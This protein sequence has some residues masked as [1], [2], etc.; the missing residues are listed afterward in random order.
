MDGS[1]LTQQGSITFIGSEPVE[2][3]QPIPV[4]VIYANEGNVHYEVQSSVTIYDAQGDVLDIVESE[5]AM[6]LPGY[7]RELVASWVPDSDLGPGTYGAQAIVYL[8]DGTLLDEANGSF[9]LGVP[10]VRP[11]PSTSVT[12]TADGHSI[13]ETEDGTISISIPQGA[14]F[15]QVEIS[16]QS[17]PI[18]QLA[19][20]PSGY[21][22]AAAAFRVEGL[23][24]LLA[25]E[26]TV[27][28]QYTATDLHRA[29][30]EAARLRL[31]RWD[32]AN[33][34]WIV[35]ETKL[36]PETMTISTTTDRF[37]IWAIMV[38]PPTKVNWI[39]IGGMAA[40]VIVV[41]LLVY[42]LAVRRRP[43]N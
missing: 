32:E 13:L 29:E 37:S 36:D 39:P 4:K 26:A 22:L 30:G 12:I 18:E 40:G 33:S 11:S 21:H 41:A 6:V 25:K 15:S 35:L 27:A 16:L 17:Y 24:G 10:Y 42:F 2:S 14:V 7:S 28:V 23:P 31:A 5:M 3:G 8:K 19:S 43:T 20:P 9:E 38:A 34:R 1:H